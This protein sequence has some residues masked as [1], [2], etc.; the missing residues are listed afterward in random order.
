MIRKEGIGIKLDH[1]RGL[2]FDLDGVLLSTDRFHFLAWKSVADEIGVPF[3]EADNEKLRGVSR[4][5]SLEII[6]S[7]APE[8]HLTDEEKHAVTERKN[9]RYRDCL[10]T[11]KPAD[12]SDEVRSTLAR[13]RERGYRLAVGSSSKNA[14]FILERVELTDAFDAVVDGTRVTNSKPDPEVFRKAAHALSV[15][16]S[17]C[18]VIEDAEAGL[19]AAVDGEMFPIAIGGACASPLAGLALSSFSDLLEFFPVTFAVEG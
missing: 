12:V 1:I 14:G 8:L 10:R 19:R 5:R 17:E 6:L 7:A 13:L 16:A 11:M 2:I 4:A 9:A 3:T 15:P 18:A